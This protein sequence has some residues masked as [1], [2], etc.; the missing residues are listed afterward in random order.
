MTQT[1][2]KKAA[3]FM[4]LLA[5][6]VASFGMDTE[7]AE[8]V[9]S[10]KTGF[11]PLNVGAAACVKEDPSDNGAKGGQ[12]RTRIPAVPEIFTFSELHFALSAEGVKEGQKFRYR[13][14]S[15][16]DVFPYPEGPVS[17][18]KGEWNQSIIAAGYNFNLFKQSPCYQRWASHAFYY[19][20]FNGQY[21][22]IESWCGWRKS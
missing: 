21:R 18:N 3:I 4:L 17:V 13:V 15:A 19:N 12:R 9:K 7:P 22:A 14:A 10:F 16:W 1:I 2:H 8:Q 11:T 20:C 6:P 5:V